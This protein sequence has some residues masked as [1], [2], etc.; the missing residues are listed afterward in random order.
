[1]ARVIDAGRGTQITAAYTASRLIHDHRNQDENSWGSPKASPKTEAP[2][3]VTKLS[4]RCRAFRYLSEVIN[5]CQA[6]ALNETGSTVTGPQRRRSAILWPAL[7]RGP[8][9]WPQPTAAATPTDF[10]QS[11]GPAGGTT[12]TTVPRRAVALWAD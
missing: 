9:H 5:V 8:E 6:S 1:V 11:Y 12:L 2:L 7:P 10:V 4:D 3:A